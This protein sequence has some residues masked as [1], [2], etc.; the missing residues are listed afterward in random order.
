MIALYIFLGLLGL[1]T[2]LLVLPAGVRVR[3]DSRGFRLTLVYGPVRWRLLP[4][5]KRSKRE[6]KT[7]DKPLPAEPLPVEPSVETPKAS[8]VVTEPSPP[9]KKGGNLKALWD[10]VPT[11]L[12]LLGAVRRRLLLRKLELLVNLAGDDPCDLAVLY[13]RAWAAVG[14]ATA[15]LENAFRIRRRNIQVFCDFTAE[16][17]QAY[18]DLEIVA[19]PARLL[20][21]ALRYGWRLLRQYLANKKAKKAVQSI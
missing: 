3:Y 18:L 6:K 7:M 9:E 2:L 13:G 15:L 11:C 17:I 21:V 4:R 8:G 5:K 19:C 14:S 20:A 10:Y 16:E 12:E 1:L